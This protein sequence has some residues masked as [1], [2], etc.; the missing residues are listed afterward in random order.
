MFNGNMISANPQLPTTVST[1]Q[2]TVAMKPGNGLNQVPA[3]V[4]DATPPPG[5]TLVLQR[6]ACPYIPPNFPG[7]ANYNAK[8]PLNPYITVDYMQLPT[9]DNRVANSTQFVMPPPGPEWTYRTYGRRQPYYG[10]RRD[11]AAAVRHCRAGIQ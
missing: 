7:Y 4:P 6:L 10:S 5:T 1:P 2:M 3:Q 9:T 11:A 8:L